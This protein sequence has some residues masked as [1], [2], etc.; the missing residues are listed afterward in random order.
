MPNKTHVM[1]DLETLNNNSTAPIV[2]LG[3]CMFWHEGKPRIAAGEKVEGIYMVCDYKWYDLPAFKSLFPMSMD[4]V[5][6]WLRQDKKAQQALTEA[7]TTYELPQVLD[8]FARWLYD[9]SGGKPDRVCLW[10]NGASFD[11]V[12]LANAYKTLGIEPPWKFWN[13]RCHRTIKN[14]YPNVQAPL[15]SAEDKHNAFNDAVNQA[16]HL[17]LIQQQTDFNLDNM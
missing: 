1:V 17:L 12:V 10:G 16:T 7:E 5:F 13:D 14:L 3:A 9:V 15:L 2:S 4:T 11:N 8:A 6:W